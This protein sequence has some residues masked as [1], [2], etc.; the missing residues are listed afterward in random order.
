MS[1]HAWTEDQLVEQLAFGLRAHSP[2][3]HRVMK[4]TD[5]VQKFLPLVTQSDIF[6]RR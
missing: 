1:P 5:S 2:N 3:F 4:T 6:T